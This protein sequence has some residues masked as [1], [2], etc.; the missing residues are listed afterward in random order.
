MEMIEQY[1]GDYMQKMG[2]DRGTLAGFGRQHPGNEQEPFGMT[3]L[4]LKLANVSN[5]V[6][7]CTAAC[8][9]RCGR[10][11]GPSCRRARCRSRAITNGVHTQ[12]WLSPEI[13]RAL[14]PVPRHPVGGAADRLRHL[15]AGRTHPGRANCG[16]RTSAAASGWWRSPGTRLQAQLKRRGSP[17]SEVAAAEEVLDPDAL[18]IGLRPA[19]RDLQAR[20]PDLPQR[21]AARGDHEQQGPAGADHLRGQGPP[22]GQRREGTDPARRAAGAEARVPP[23]GGVHRG[24]RHER[25]ALPRAG[26]GRVAEQ[27][28]PAAR[29]LRHERDEGRRATAG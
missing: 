17:P 4:A 8:R 1:L 10:T 12:S 20:R 7:G 11:C 9:G 23:A 22:E 27:P 21:R 26:R 25:R 19:V 16:G 5:G 24:L 29:G 2:V 15:E 3:V 18:T 14:R 28:A 13:A 6:R